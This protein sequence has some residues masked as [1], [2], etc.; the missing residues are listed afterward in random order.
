M[1]TRKPGHGLGPPPAAFRRDRRAADE[2]D[3][4]A[5]GH[6]VFGA[7]GVDRYHLIERLVRELSSRGHRSTVLCFDAAEFAFWAAQGLATVRVA[8]GAPLP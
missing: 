8:P 4:S 1:R 3:L 6:I 2:T 7:P 5:M